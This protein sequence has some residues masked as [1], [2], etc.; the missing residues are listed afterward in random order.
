[1]RG[2][3]EYPAAL[4]ELGYGYAYLARFEKAFAVFERY[5]AIAPT[6]PN[7]HDSFGEALPYREREQCINGR[8]QVVQHHT[9]A[10]HIHGAR[11]HFPFASLVIVPTEHHPAPQPQTRTSSSVDDMCRRREPG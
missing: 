2:D 7:P 11:Q 4:N 1:M 8:E 10:A 3:A 5:S 9:G 6:Q